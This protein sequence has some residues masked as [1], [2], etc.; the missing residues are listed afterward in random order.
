VSAA[1]ERVL[2]TA[3]KLFH[4]EGIRAVGVDRIAAEARVGKMTLYRHFATKDDLVVAVLEGRDGP[5]R[6]ALDAAMEHAGEDPVVRLLAP[7]AM[8]EPWFTSPGFRGCPFMNASLELHD[9]DHPARAVARRHKAA[10]RD[11]FARAA[12]DAGRPDDEADALADQL[13]LLFDGAIAQAQMR[14]PRTVARAARAAAQALVDS[15]APPS[16]SGSRQP[17]GSASTSPSPGPHE[18]GS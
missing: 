6:A 4:R 1:R 15:A 8:L 7:F 16:V 17:T 3:G 10:T 2:K 5:A 12:R 18:P 11:A 14:D 9:P 13:A